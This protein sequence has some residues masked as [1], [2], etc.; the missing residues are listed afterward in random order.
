MEVQPFYKN[1]IL[2]EWLISQQLT[3]RL[4]YNTFDIWM[5]SLLGTV[6]L[7]KNSVVY[8]PMGGWPEAHYF[9]VPA[10]SFGSPS[11]CDTIRGVSF[12]QAP[13]S[14]AVAQPREQLIPYALMICWE[15]LSDAIYNAMAD[16]QE[17]KIHG[18]S[19]IPNA[20]LVNSPSSLQLLSTKNS[21]TK[22]K[23]GLPEI[24]RG[25]RFLMLILLWPNQYSLGPK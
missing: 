4:Q 16:Y 3:S 8:F 7:V 19:I 22:W 21:A 25:H 12:D 1:Q 23:I 13:N 5:P 11:F 20:L 24:Y 10:M 9:S 15:K 2:A 17:H 14:L 6:E 18:C